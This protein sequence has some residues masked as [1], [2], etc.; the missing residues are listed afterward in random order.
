[1]DDGIA[2]IASILETS[3]MLFSTLKEAEDSKVR[4]RDELIILL[5]RLVLKYN[6]VQFA[7]RTFQQVI[8]TAMGTSCAP[9]YANLFLASYEAPALEE[10]KSFLL[11]YKRFIDDTF[12]IIK[13]TREDVERFQERF[14]SLHPNMRMEWTVS[15]HHLPFLDIEVS[16]GP[17]P[18][19]PSLFRKQLGISTN[20]FQKA[21]NAYLYIPWNSCHSVDSKRAWVKGELIRYVRI[22]SKESDFAL[23]RRDF[24]CRLNARGYPGRW[25][26]SVF[27]E[28]EYRTERPTALNPRASNDACAGGSELHVLKLTHNPVWDVIDFSPIWRELG[29]AWREFGEAYPEFR[30][31]ASYNK[32]HALGDRLNVHNRE[33]CKAAYG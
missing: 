8:G 28:I 26:Q 15:Q 9:T 33:T 24:A 21:L 23:V 20:I 32:P 18:M 2:Q 17:D 4:G 14:G 22:C 27:G 31:M 7:G 29:D 1:M 10:F 3:P 12:A 6:F 13:G 19:R 5:L 11:F 25:L 16:L 30:F